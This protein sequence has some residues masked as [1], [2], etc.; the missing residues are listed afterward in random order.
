RALFRD[1]SAL[2][3][4]TTAVTTLFILPLLLLPPVAAGPASPSPRRGPDWTVSTA[5]IAQHCEYMPPLN[6]TFRGSPA[7]LSYLASEAFYLPSARVPSAPLL[8]HTFWTGPLREPLFLTLR[9][10]LF[11]QA[12]G[13]RNATAG[14]QAAQL[15]VWLAAGLPNTS[16]TTLTS[17]DLDPNGDIPFS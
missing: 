2:L 9:S 14:R 13:P 10:F 3:A 5:L 4:K 11:T 7:C 6:G 15:W 1:A 12:T 8:F 17:G 16:S